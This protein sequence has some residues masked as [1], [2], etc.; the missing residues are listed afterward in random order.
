MYKEFARTIGK[1]AMSLSEMEKR[2]ATFVGLLKEGAI[3]QGNMNILTATYLGK[4]QKLSQTIFKAKAAFGDLIKT[5]LTPFVAEIEKVIAATAK[6]IEEN[7][8]LIKTEVKVFLETL[9]TA[10]KVTWDMLVG[11]N[12]ALKIFGVN[13]KDV[14]I[15]FTLFKG[16]TLVLTKVVALFTAGGVALKILRGVAI[17]VTATIAG[18]H[19]SLFRLL[20]VFRSTFTA[21]KA[22]MPILAGLKM[23]MMALGG[24]V[25][26]IIGLVT[27]AAAAWA[28]FSLKSKQAMKETEEATRQ[29]KTELRELIQ[30]RHDESL[31]IV[32]NLEKKLADKKITRDQRIE[33]EKLLIVEREHEQFLR[34]RK[35]VED[36]RKA[37]EEEKK[38]S[39]MRFE[40]VERFGNLSRDLQKEKM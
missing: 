34:T 26:I 32:T 13:I 21:I 30:I 22:G 38:I 39:K 1:G 37:F 33:V 4:T 14:I 36:A 16:I 5:G 11:V 31:S 19:R 20:L 28:Y 3:F 9:T 2:Q 7:E 24:P 10:L 8:V 23:A 25:T 18:F 29:Y 27:A 12:N 17:G 35:V 15:F 6:W 40:S